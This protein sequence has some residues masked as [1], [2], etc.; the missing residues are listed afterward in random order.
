M[1]RW[2]AHSLLAVA[3][4][5]LITPVVAQNNRQADEAYSEGVKYVNRREFD[6]ARAP[7]ET[8][9]QL[10]PDNK[11]RLKVFQALTRV[12][13]TLPE[14]DKMTEASEYVIRYSDQ[15]AERSSA[16]SSL[17]AFYFQRG[18]VDEQLKRY[19]EIAAAEA[20]DYVALAM[21]AELA[22]PAQLDRATQQAYRQKFEQAEKKLAAQLAERAEQA[23]NVDATQKTWL[24]KEAAV[25]WSKSGDHIKAVQAAQQAEQTGP[26]TRALLAHFWHAQLG[27]VY[28]S[29]GKYSEAIKHLEQAIEKTSVQG[30]KDSCQAKLSQAKE[31]LAGK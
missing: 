20:D 31:K 21:L 3:L 2:L 15:L 29:A 30:Y 18:K 27:D 17:A 13:R 23:A 6:K 25:L 16:A 12:Y 14:I 7:L 22:R 9:L 26:E 19:R 10:A 11:F 28:L 4:L 1:I 24:W 8:A 5:G